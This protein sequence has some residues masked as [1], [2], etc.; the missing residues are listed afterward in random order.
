MCVCRL[1][2][3]ANKLIH[4]DADTFESVILSFFSLQT[5]FNHLF[6]CD[7]VY[8]VLLDCALVSEEDFVKHNGHFICCYEYVEMQ[9]CLMKF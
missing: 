7:A 6:E 8:A 9:F 4:L 1:E 5:V 2:C 3:A